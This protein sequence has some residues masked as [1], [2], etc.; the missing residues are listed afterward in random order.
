MHTQQHC[1]AICLGSVWCSRQSHHHPVARPLAV[2]GHAR[3]A[4][5]PCD[6]VIYAYVEVN[7]LSL[8]STLPFPLSPARPLSVVLLL[9]VLA[10]V[11]PAPWL[12]LVRSHAPQGFRPVF[13]P[14]GRPGRPPQT[15]LQGDP[16]IVL[17]RR[18]PLPQFPDGRPGRPVRL[19][20]GHRHGV[21]LRDI[22]FLCALVG[23][24]FPLPPAPCLLYVSLLCVRL[25]C[26]CCFF[27]CP[28][29]PALRC[30]RAPWVC[31]LLFSVL[32]LLAAPRHLTRPSPLPFSFSQATLPV[33]LPSLSEPRCHLCVPP[34]CS[35]PAPL[36]RPYPFPWGLPHPSVPS[37]PFSHPILVALCPV[38][39]GGVYLRT[40]LWPCPRTG[41]TVG[42]LRTMSHRILRMNTK[43]TTVRHLS[44]SLRCICTVELSRL[45]QLR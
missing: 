29:V 2:P 7:L 34:A 19:N 5:L 23:P 3:W 44:N 28:R 17:P 45:E 6:P 38:P 40:G 1:I 18:P 39:G 21:S 11:V 20:A 43:R 4:P 24:L 12:F 42:F 13:G 25:F 9:R 16:P 41:M 31:P 15:P 37:V 8:L 30:S 32:P 27:W 22:V 35:T 36:R 26:C 14:V 33:R 10:A